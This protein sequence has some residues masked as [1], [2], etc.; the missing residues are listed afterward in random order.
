MKQ[1]KDFESEE[2]FL[3]Y[4]ASEIEGYIMENDITEGVFIP[5]L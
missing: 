3:H 2:Q 5:E 4:L 1:L